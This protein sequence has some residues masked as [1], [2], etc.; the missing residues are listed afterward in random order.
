MMPEETEAI[1][2][3]LYLDPPEGGVQRKSS[4]MG[5]LL[6]TRAI[7]HRDA[8][9]GELQAGANDS[10]GW[11]AAIGY[12]VLLDQIGN[13]FTTNGAP[14]APQEDFVHALQRFS[15][16]SD[17]EIEAL[18]AMRCALA[19]DYSLV[20]PGKAKRRH[21][22][23]YADHPGGPAVQLPAAEWSGSYSDPVPPAQT[24]R[25]NLRAVG[26]LAESVVSRLRELHQ[27][28]ELVLRLDLDEFRMRYTMY[29][30]AH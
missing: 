23:E 2:R 15:E 26:D 22:F 8:G 9:T 24:T 19:H 21:V 1:R 4:F 5:A 12:V 7:A 10:G 6:D 16:L 28:G 14:P 18:Y 27:A 13:C 30:A 3:H 29:Y 17:G 20:N 11:L 25:V